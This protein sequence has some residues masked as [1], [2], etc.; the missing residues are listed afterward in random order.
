MKKYS[1]ILMSIVIVTLVSCGSGSTTKV[2]TDSTTVK[3]DTV[4][5]VLDSTKS[6]DTLKAVK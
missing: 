5:Q 2:S 4:T 3:S 6:V 1:L